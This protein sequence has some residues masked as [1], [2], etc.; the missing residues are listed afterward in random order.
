MVELNVFIKRIQNI[1]KFLKKVAPD[2]LMKS[3]REIIALNN[4][5][6][7]EGKNADDKIMQQGY[8]KAYGNKRRKKGLQTSFVDLKFSGF[9]Q[10]SKKGEKAEGGINIVSGASYEK[11]LRG[12]FHNHVGLTKRNA[13]KVADLISEPLAELIKNYISK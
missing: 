1:D 6:L 7:L 11:Y 8:S 2:V 13:D 5:Q 4:V 3:E 9:Y 10:E 12:N